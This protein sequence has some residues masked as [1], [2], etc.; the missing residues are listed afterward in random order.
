MKNFRDLLSEVAQPKSPE[1]KR[2][3]DQHTIELIKHPVAPD[4]VHTGEI[5]GVT[6]KKRVADPD[7]GQDVAKYDAAYSEKDKP[8]KMPRNIDEGKVECPQCEGEGCDHCDDKGYHIAEQ[9]LEES[10]RN[11]KVTKD[12][13]TRMLRKP[14]LSTYQ[15]MGWKVVKEETAKKGI[16]FKNLLDKIDEEVEDTFEELQYVSEDPQEEVPMMMRQ[17]HFIGY[18]ADE[19]MEYLAA[20]DIDPEEWYQNKLANAF[21]MM[22]TL[23]AYVEG[24]K[25]VRS[26]DD[27]K[28]IMAGY[29]GE[30][31]ELEEANFKPSNL[32]LKS[33]E[34]VK[35]SM[36]DAKV[37][38]QMMK[39]LNAKN[40]K[41][42]EDSLMKDKKGFQEIL[43]FAR[44]AL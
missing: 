2:F 38:N 22:K 36:D 30:E 11:I 32:K 12:G 14:E 3:K 17:L 26:M 44:E 10:P 28:S 40:K 7:E 27:A 42:M 35:L 4:Y 25:R 18:A 23:H 9:S 15:Q 5:E 16:S 6:K 43:D 34:T 33:G 1:E 39:T 29:Y 24:D 41:Q 19:I 31:V 21:S 20:D 37:L 13:K 8:F